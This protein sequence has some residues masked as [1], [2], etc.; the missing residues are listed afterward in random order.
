MPQSVPI[1]RVTQISE[2]HCGPAVLQ[3]QL[4]TLGHTFSQ[5]EITRAA[6]AEFTIKD[7]GVTVDQLG[8]ACKILAPQ[9][10]FWYKYHATF[11]D[12][13][14][15]LERGFPVGVEWKGLFYESEEEEEAEK[16][17]DSDFGHYSVVSHMDDELEELIMV[18]PYKEFR[19]RNRIFE[20]DFFRRRWWDTNDIKDPTTGQI[21]TIK[22]EQ[23]LFFVAPVGTYFP[24]ELGFKAFT[25]VEE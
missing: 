23:L 20:Y 10:Q 12:I 19:D 25:L 13:R 11:D 3:M 24:R 8:K 22:D 15:L 18:D 17:D 7:T 5:E 9:T 1:N 4:E 21:R 14:Y 6:D 16:D 2:D